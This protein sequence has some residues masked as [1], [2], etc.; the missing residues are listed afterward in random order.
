[1]AKDYTA[2]TTANVIS[3][4]GDA[5]LTVADPS[6]TNTG[7]LV[8]GS[9]SLAQPLQVAGS[10]L[11]R[12]VKTWAAPVSNDAVTIG[13]KQYDRRERG[14][15]DRRLQ[16]DADVH[17]VHHDA[18]RGVPRSGARRSGAPRIASLVWLGKVTTL[19]SFAEGVRLQAQN[20]QAGLVDVRAALAVDG[21]GSGSHRDA[22]PD[23]HRRE[24][25]RAGTG[26]QRAARGGAPRVCDPSVRAL[27]ATASAAS[28]TPSCWSRSRARAPRSS[29]CSSASTAR[30][31]SRSAPFG[32][33][34]L[35]QATDAWL[36]LGHEIDTAVS[37]LGYTATLQT[38]GLLTDALLEQTGEWDALPALV[39][40]TLERLAPHARELA[41]AFTR[42][43]ACST[44]SAPGPPRGSAGEAALL[45]R[46]ALLLPAAEY[47]TRQYLHG[48]MES[49]ATGFG[50]VLFGAEREL[51]LAQTLA[52]YGATVA[53]IGKGADFLVGSDPILQILPMQLL[54]QYV[55]ELR[56]LRVD[57]L[58]R[59]QDDTKVA[60][61]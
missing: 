45:A 22:D 9:F 31:R 44:P 25:A 14:A 48:P 15:P 47:E 7:H 53:T 56:G 39:D 21:S 17:A 58:A 3:T 50:A 16:Q 2:S 32:D 28:A 10:P 4:A 26:D 38:L 19:R 51:R 12:V 24:L 6:A 5:T 59:E 1:M 23:G 8:N 55:A 54:V 35:A 33:S 18:L 29:T 27:R 49:V 34:P 11:P 57:S 41:P 52:G 37:T 42:D 60:T 43:H 20:L 36:P 13:F 30:R 46:E 61:R 40:A